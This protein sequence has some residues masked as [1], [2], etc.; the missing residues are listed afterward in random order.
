M[1]PDYINQTQAIQR[2]F[3]TVAEVAQSQWNDELTEKY[4]NK[5]V[6]IYSEKLNAFMYGGDIYGP[7]IDD[8]VQFIDQQQQKMEKVVSGSE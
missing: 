8:L 5:Y 7:S 1:I 3:E 6:N 4:Y 2:D